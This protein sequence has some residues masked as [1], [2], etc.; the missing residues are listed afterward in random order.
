MIPVLRTLGGPE[1]V[2]HQ[3]DTGD[4][5]LTF[6][7]G[8]GGRLLSVRC[9]GA[10][11]LW[12]NP[13]YVDR[14][15]LRTVRPR[16]DWAPL[17]GTMGSWANV[18]GSKTWP[19][20]QGWT[21]DTEWAG[22]P[23]PV[24]DSGAW[25]MESAVAADGTVHL[26]MASPDD[27]RT[28][29]RIIREL[30]VPAGRTF[31]QRSTFRNVSD[32]PVRWSVWEVAQVD[33]GGGPGWAPEDGTITVSV[34]DDA[35]PLDM[36]AAVGRVEVGPR[37]PDGRREVPVRA[38]VGK[39]GFTTADGELAFHRPDG[40]GLTLRFDPVLGAPYPDGGARVELWMQCPQPTPLDDW[41]GL[42]PDAWLTELEVLGPL[43]DLAPGEETALDLT[44][45]IDPPTR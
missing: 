16:P 38:A 3:V 28:G 26:R 1:P 14:G 39:V 2:P 27:P 12:Q 15:S 31:T 9:G 36:I 18:G 23:D 7:P 32:R 20:P 8:L 11:L 10:E 34:S 6:L 44:W 25:T 17:D 37:G 40:A 19:A 45:H 35:A 43:V 13:A 33:T 41:G 5:C 4:L 21:D 30:T 29:L 24:L 22:P 42:H